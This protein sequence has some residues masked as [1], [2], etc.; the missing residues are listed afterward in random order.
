MADLAVVVVNYN[1]GEHLLRCLASVYASAGDLSLDVVVVDNASRDGSAARAAA[2]HPAVRLLENPVNRGFAAAANRGIRESDAPCVFLLNPDAEVI[3]GTLASLLKIANDRPAAGV[4]GVLVRNTDGTLQPSARKVPGIAEGLGH[5]FLG[6]VRPDN[7]FTRSYTM[8]GWDRESEREVDW[9]S[10][11]A[12]LLRRAAL[13]E[14]GLFDEG[15][16]MYV[17]DVDLCTRMRRAGWTVLFSPELQVTHVTG[18][19]SRSAPRRMAHE[20]SKSI[21]RY[22]TKHVA[23]GPSAALKPLARAALW[24]RASLVARRADVPARRADVPA[25]RPPTP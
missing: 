10:G 1:A 4:V 18:V 16:F 13:D 20:H 19:S 23:T 22:F 2:V 24:A 7:P 14:V 8:A 25:R 21:Y 11:S 5:A 17:E 12:M 15:Y 3:G 6:P 9:V